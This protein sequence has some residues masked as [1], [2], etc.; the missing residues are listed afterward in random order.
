MRFLDTFTKTLV[1]QE[2]V[3]ALGGRLK[4]I[5]AKSESHNPLLE[6]EKKYAV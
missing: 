4:T 6:L 1:I 3:D 2:D 5:Y